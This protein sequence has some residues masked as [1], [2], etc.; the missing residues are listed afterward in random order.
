MRRAGRGG[1]AAPVAAVF[2]IHRPHVLLGGCGACSDSQVSEVLA[3]RNV[4]SQHKGPQGGPPREGT[5]KRPPGVRCARRASWA[6]TIVVPGATTPP[7]RLVKRHDNDQGVHIHHRGEGKGRRRLPPLCNCRLNALIS[8]SSSKQRCSI[9]THFYDHS[10]CCETS[11]YSISTSLAPLTRP[12]LLSR[13]PLGCRS[14]QAAVPP[15]QP[16]Q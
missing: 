3:P 11:I 10:I 2:E 8:I 14:G 9:V 6:T 13:L 16:F 5:A 4:P 12:L 15:G 7:Q 1:T